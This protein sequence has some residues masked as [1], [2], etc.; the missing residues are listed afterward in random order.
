[1][2]I[3]WHGSYPIYLEDAREY[4]GREYGLDYSKFYNNGYFAPLVD[5]HIEYKKVITHAQQIRVDIFYCPTKAA[6]VVYEYE[7][8]DSKENTLLAVAR[9]VQVFTDYNHNLCLYSP[10]FYTEWKRKWNVEL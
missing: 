6:K 8:R 4:F 1:M 5:M 2:R 9:T 7:I 10:D 3:A